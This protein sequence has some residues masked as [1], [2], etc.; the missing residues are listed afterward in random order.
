MTEHAPIADYDALRRALA[1]FRS[2]GGRL[3][4][5]DAGAGFASLKHVLQL[6]PDILKVDSSVIG[7]IRSDRAARAL[8]TAL[9]SFASEMGE[10]VVAEGVEDDDTVAVLRQ[11]GV[12]YCQGF[13]F[14][15]P[16]PLPIA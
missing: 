9:L 3:A 14:G 7:E 12:P 2:N 11:L 6:G 10:L 1:S 4:V 8:T 15:A 13:Y 5:D 16:A